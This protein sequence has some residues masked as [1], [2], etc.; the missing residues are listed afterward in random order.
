M[1]GKAIIVGA[2]PAG[3]TAS[4]ELLRR[5]QIHPVIVEES[6]E[7]GGISRT[8]NYKGNRLDIGGHRFFSKDKRILRWWETIMTKTIEDSERELLTINRVSHI[9]FLR[10]FFSYPI[11]L[12]KDTFLNL[13]LRNALR[14]G[15]GYIRARLFPTEELTLEDFY[16]NRFGRPLYE[17]FFE[18]Y[19]T[20]VWGK[21]P[22]EL[23]A[24]WGRQRVKGLSLPVVLEDYFRKST[25]GDDRSKEVEASLIEC[26]RY[27]KYGPGQLWECVAEDVVRKGA[28]L[29]K[30]Q[31]VRKIHVDG[32]RVRSV[33]IVG[34]N[35]EWTN[36]VCDYFFSSMSIK[37]LVAA[38]E[39]IVV[40]E[41][42]RRIAA[43]LPYR[44]FITVGLLVNKLEFL[45]EKGANLL[46][47]TWI[48]IQE[49][50]VKVG[51]LQI[52]NNWSPFL[53]KDPEH[54]VWIGLE[55]FCDEND[56]LWNMGEED[57]IQMAIGE[58]ENIDMLK[59]ESVID[60]HQVKVKKAYPAYFGSY[61]ELEEVRRFLDTIENLYC[62]GRNGQHKYNNMDHSMLTAMEAVSNVENH[63]LGKDNIWLVNTEQ[64]Y[65]EK[66]Y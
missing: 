19:T 9:Y 26:F 28:E 52:F 42:V 21:H 17:L 2:G 15:L 7:V 8:V 56:E 32:N 23:C 37:D 53:V 59:R 64:R 33:D 60:A 41:N 50:D 31:S 39:G 24:D 27:P 45:K 57:F 58:M 12:S 29:R 30:G 65:H 1:E 40:P 43:D 66:V 25:R 46:P 22:S 10:K 55:Y 20:K 51:R 63:I 18:D 35:G 48:Y 3:L 4:Y 34:S 6:E 47:D 54:T 49:R 13:G 5:T 38:L 36:E 44:D 62:I 14:I 61:G 16:I 11:S